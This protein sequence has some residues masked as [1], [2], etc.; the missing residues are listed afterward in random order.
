[1]DEVKKDEAALSKEA[2]RAARE[3]EE[4][5]RQ[6][7]KDAKREARR[8][9][10]E[11]KEDK[12]EKKEKARREEP[13]AT[14]Q[15]RRPRKWGKMVST[16]L[17]VV[18]VGGLIAI[19]VMPVS[20]AEYESAASQALGRP[21]KVSSANLSLYS[22]VQ[23]K[24]SGVSVGDTKIATVR[25]FPEIGSLFDPKKRFTRI[26]LDGVTVPQESLAG[27]FGARIRSDNFSVGRV[28]AKQ[29]KL[30]G[31][32]TLPPLEVDL[33]LAEDGNVTSTSVR[34]PEGLSGKITPKGSGE[35]DL[36]IVAHSFTVPVLPDF[37]M[38]GFAMKGVATPA[39]L[40]IES[41]GGSSLDGAVSG[42]ANVRWSS[43]N[44]V[45]DGVLTIRGIN[46][47]VF[48]P[49]LL[50][51]GKAE[52][53]GRFSFNDAD[54]MAFLSRGR[55]EGTYSVH[56]G[57]LG[58]FDL[59]R[60]IQ[61]G[62]RQAQGRTPFTGLTGQGVFD[63]GAV[64]LRNVSFNAGAMN[65]GASADIAADGNLSGRIVADIRTAAQTLRATLNLGG[66]VKDPQVRN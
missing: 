37:S 5:E 53:T 27:L 19:H 17:F 38:S 26:E 25:G 50:S 54:P 3:R 13:V 40:R 11:E 32:L 18:L 16:T 1:M 49:A 34:G 23:L 55:I 7:K 21:V 63:K 24:F 39:G 48:A 51:E 52:G 8:A 30:T 62:G 42:N 9:K 57:V 22:G 44:W 46:A 61:T 2:R 60:A 64:A 59:S 33:A 12:K 41:W 56:K 14:P 31:P 47:A 4:R 35:L 15:F 66:T 20:T 6:A 10:E 28:L 29:V 43:G 45:M 36:D 58:S 65:A